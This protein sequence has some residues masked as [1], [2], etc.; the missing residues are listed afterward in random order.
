MSKCKSVSTL[1]ATMVK[2][3]ITTGEQLKE[4]EAS[5]YRSIVG[6][7]QYLMLTQPD[8]SFVVNKVCQFLHSPTTL[9][10]EAIKRILRYVQGTLKV[11]L[12]FY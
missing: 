11:G 7:Q 4:E 2:L 8:I 1:L 9:H 5:Q 6:G 10:V 12:K 3:S